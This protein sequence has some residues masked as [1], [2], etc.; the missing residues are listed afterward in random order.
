MPPTIGSIWPPAG[1][2]KVQARE[3]YACRGGLSMSVKGSGPADVLGRAWHGLGGKGK[4]VVYFE[5]LVRGG[6]VS[7]ARN[8][9]VIHS[10]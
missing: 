4:G 9:Q 1:K 6:K 5:E 10:L 8:R 3:R 2:R 7:Q